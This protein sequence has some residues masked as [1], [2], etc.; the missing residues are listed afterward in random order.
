MGTEKWVRQQVR[1]HGSS[2]RR[3]KMEGRGGEA[4]QTSPSQAPDHWGL[5][6]EAAAR[7]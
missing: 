4:G 7:R 1:Q 5:T 2:W 6:H 3:E